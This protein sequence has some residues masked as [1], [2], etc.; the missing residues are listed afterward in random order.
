MDV[1]APSTTER[2]LAPFRRLFTRPTF[3]HLGGLAAGALLASGPRT[4]AAGLRALGRGDDPGFSSFHRVLNAARWSALAA[5]RAL[6]L[7]LVAA[8]APGG[9][10]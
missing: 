9:P 7:L 5:A 4:V 10:V 8:F 1:V 6:L 2:L 3:E